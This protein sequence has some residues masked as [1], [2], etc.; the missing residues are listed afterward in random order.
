MSKRKPKEDCAVEKDKLEVTKECEECGKR[1]KNAK[2]ALLCKCKVIL[3]CDHACLASSDHFGSCQERM[4]PVKIDMEAFTKAAK[5]TNFATGT[6]GSR[7][8]KK[9]DSVKTKHPDDMKRLAEEGN[10]FAAYMIG[11]SYS[12]RTATALEGDETKPAISFMMSPKDLKKSVGETDEEAIKWFLIAEGM[13]S[14]A[15][16]LWADNGLKTDS[17]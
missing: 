9:L 4:K 17:R 11:C 6:S 13:D 1:I 16:K 2:K 14:L 3:F 10:P 8:K 5:S 7:L 15:A 12:L